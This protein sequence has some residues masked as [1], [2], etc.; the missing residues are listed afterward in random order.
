MTEKSS[1][2][3]LNKLETFRQAQTAMRNGYANGSIGIIVS[4]LIWLTSAIIAYQYSA[5]KSNLGTLHWRNVHLPFE[6]VN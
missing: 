3:S 4:G 2:E 1:S 6:Y 5:P